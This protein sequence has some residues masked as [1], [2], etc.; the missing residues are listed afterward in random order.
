MANEIIPRWEWRAFDKGFGE[1][2]NPFSAYSGSGVKESDELYFLSSVASENA[3]VRDGLIDIKILQQVNP[4]GLEQ[5]KPVLK[6]GFP[7]P[8]SGA[9]KVFD[10]LGVDPPNFARPEYTLQQFAD[11]LMKPDQRL[12]A[13]SIHKK[14]ARYN[15]EGCMAEL[16]EVT[17]EGKTTHTVALESEDPARVIATVRKLGLDRCKNTSYPKGLKQLLGM[18]G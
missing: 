9:K 14:R 5:W 17:A 7:L 18:N 4:A 16:T 6:E 11:E 15:V 1:S 10:M 8:A 13:V 3:K 2:N 12:R